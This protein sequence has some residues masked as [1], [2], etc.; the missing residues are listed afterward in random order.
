MSDAL[1]GVPAT[2][3]SE[4]A[5]IKVITDRLNKAARTG[6]DPGTERKPAGTSSGGPYEVGPPKPKAAV[7]ES[8]TTTV[9]DGSTPTTRPPPSTTTTTSRTTVI[10]R[11]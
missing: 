10:P 11:P 5:P 2:E 3:F 9:D 7:P 8:T 4:P 6:I 1:K